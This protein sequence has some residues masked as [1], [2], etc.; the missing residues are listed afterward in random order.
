M[1]VNDDLYF[2]IVCRITHELLRINFVFVF[3]LLTFFIKN[4]KMYYNIIK[5]NS[6]SRPCW[7]HCKDRPTDRDGRCWIRRL[8]GARRPV[9]FW[10]FVALSHSLIVYSVFTVVSSLFLYYLLVYSPGLGVCCHD[11]WYEIKYF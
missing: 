10:R 11:S 9:A 4:I 2:M 5:E 3:I 8:P 6:F 1:I 7:R